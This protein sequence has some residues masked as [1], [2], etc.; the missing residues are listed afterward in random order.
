M[1]ARN[2]KVTTK[3]A[4]TV[5][6]A[7]KIAKPKRTESFVEIDGRSV[8]LSN[9]Q[10]VLWP[11]D[12]YTKG[13]LVAYYRSVAPFLLP[14]L[15][16]R[17]LTLQRWPDG[18]HGFSFFEKNIPR[19]APSWVPTYEVAS[20]GKRATVSYVLCNDESTLVW[21]ANLGSI[22]LHVWMS[23]VEAIDNPD[24]VLFDL[25]PWEGCTLKTL[26]KVALTV[27][28]V[29]ES[30]GLTPLVK[31]SGGSGLHVVLPVKPVYDYEVLKAFGELVARRVASLRTGEVTLERMTKKRP[32]GT[33]Y[34]D[35]VQIGKG[36]TIVPPFVVRAREGAPVS[37]PLAWSEVEKMSR[38]RALDTSPEFVRWN[39][40]NVPA[41]L[42][43][44]GDPW[45][46]VARSSHL[47]L[48]PALEK[49]QATWP[50][51]ELNVDAERSQ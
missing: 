5:R 49:A 46:A 41:L 23:R 43:K 18:I 44:S 36:K 45:A 22:T 9:P 17:P 25:D 7:A 2:A 31:T 51:E 24:Y 6:P 27:Q 40:G 26:A 33:V 30:I 39:I 15:A 42:E 50:R 8:K 16:Q 47:P 28:E 34:F 13:E 14:Y 19:G 20:G 29:L 32:A 3:S 35:W 4:K 10:K 37:M 21:L 12:G 11:E 48:E 38:K 1:L